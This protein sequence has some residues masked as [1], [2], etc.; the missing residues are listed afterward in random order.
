MSDT[1][2]E[3]RPEPDKARTI[4][5]RALWR[6]EHQ[7]KMPEAGEDKK[8]AYAAVRKEYVRKAGRVI[9][10]LERQGIVFGAK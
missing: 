7:G 6:A 10:Q 9:R 3:S 1:T 8:A 4:L 2:S 5:A